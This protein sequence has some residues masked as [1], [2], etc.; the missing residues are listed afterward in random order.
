MSENSVLIYGPYPHEVRI[1][2]SLQFQ[3]TLDLDGRF[4][5]D[6]TGSYQPQIIDYLKKRAAKWKWSISRNFIP[7]KL[8]EGMDTIV[9]VKVTRRMLE[10]AHQK[11]M[12]HPYN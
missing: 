10:Y 7:I 5:L 9:N 12:K 3:L 8:Q 2:T 1:Q 6:E 4:Y 11:L